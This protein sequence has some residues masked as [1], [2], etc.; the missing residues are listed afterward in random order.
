ML[1]VS[2]S[3]SLKYEASQNLSLSANFSY[4]ERELNRRNLYPGLVFKDFRNA[5]RGIP[6]FRGD[7]DTEAGVGFMYR[8]PK[9]SLFINGFLNWEMERKAFVNIMDFTSD[10]IISGFAPAPEGTKDMSTM[11]NLDISKGVEIFKGKIGL[12]TFMMS[13][14]STMVRNDVMLPFTMRMLSLKPT[15]NGRLFSWCNLIYSID[16]SWDWMW[17]GE[18]QEAASDTKGYIQNLELIFS[19]WERFN[20]S[21]LAEHY[22]TEFSEDQAK[23]LV[24]TDFKAEYQLSEKWLL[25]ATVTNLLNQN[26]YNYTVVD[27]GNRSFTSYRIRPRNLLLSVYYKF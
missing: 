11:V 10:Y 4:A 1:Y 15:I 16:F 23:H 24:L 5:A 22:Y 20:F 6:S 27:N 17:M 14:Q 18:E 2:P 9:Y 25:Q 12:E 13:S 19:P 7:K 21:F 26:T 8:H 3:L